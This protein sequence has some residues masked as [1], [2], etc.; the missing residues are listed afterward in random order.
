MSRDITP[1]RRIGGTLRVPGDKSIAQRAALL[2]I[3]AT[4]PIHVANAPHAADANSA[5]KA[6][7]QFGVTVETTEEG[8]RLTPPAS[9]NIPS[10][11][12]VDC[13]NSGTTARLL[14]GL[15]AGS[16]LSATLAGD[17][18]LSRRP[19]KR[20]VDPLTAMGA[21][22][23][24]TD[25]HL[26]MRIQGK[27]LLPFEYTMPIPS[28]Q[29]KSAVL[30][31]GLASGCR[32]LIREK[33]LSRDHTEIML[34]YLGT[35][36]SVRDIKPVLTEDPN[37]PRRKKMVMPEDFKR[38]SILPARARVAGGSI[39]IP[40]DFSTAA[41]F[42]GLAA[43]SGK[44]I[45]VEHVGLNPTRTEFL[46]HLKAAGCKLIIENKTIVSGEPRGNVTVTGEALKAVKVHG[47]TA[48]A[49]IDELPMVAVIGA[50]AQGTTVIRDA[51]ELKVKESDRLAAIVENLRAMGV[52][53][54][55]LEDGLAIEGQRE[56]Q[57]ADLKSFG[58]HRIAMAFAIAARLA[59]GPSTI[60]DAA[61]VA[62]S[63]PVFWDLLQQVSH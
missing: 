51:A 14:A 24:A 42:F 22:C 54:G 2:S 35:G 38:E 59:T 23:Y 44:S 21:E 10:D 8:L 41:F 6:A 49:M 13:G 28:A 39:D 26:P 25:G 50:Y 63:C 60:D 45:T 53:V 62:I 55:L 11:L 32:I 20:I 7:Q 48:A 1:A 46:N 29:V 5:I 16:E 27:K 61:C 18:S 17:E 52:K 36:I 56:L 40:G 4:G 15:I 33:Q 58:D 12:I 31:A 19:M 43:I 9:L 57:G 47:E 34:G 37:D 30:F 3:L